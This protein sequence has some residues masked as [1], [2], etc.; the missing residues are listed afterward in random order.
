[1]DDELFQKPLIEALSWSAGCDFLLAYTRGPLRAIDIDFSC[2]SAEPDAAWP[3]GARAKLRFDG[4]VMSRFTPMLDPYVSMLLQA[5]VRSRPFEFSL[6]YGAQGITN[7]YHRPFG[8]ALMLLSWLDDHI[9]RHIAEH[10]SAH[11]SA[12]PTQQLSY[13]ISFRQRESWCRCELFV[14]ASTQPRHAIELPAPPWA[15]PFWRSFRS[16]AC[17]PRKLYLCAEFQRPSAHE[18]AEFVRARQRDGFA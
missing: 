10:L 8:S 1:M 5:F 3:R 12:L 2:C 14:A 16:W 15:L 11:E 9:Y 6:L 4:D 17:A 7:R 13:E 18:R